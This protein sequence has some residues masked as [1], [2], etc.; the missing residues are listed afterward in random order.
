MAACI[1]NVAFV[2]PVKPKKKN[3]P[4]ANVGFGDAALDCK[5][6]TGLVCELLNYTLAVMLLFCMFAAFYDVC[7]NMELTIVECNE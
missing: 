5:T 6:W 1:F 4:E 2:P 3:T 7:A